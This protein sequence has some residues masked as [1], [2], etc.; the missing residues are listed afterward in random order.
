MTG[1][2]VWSNPIPHVYQ[3]TPSNCCPASFVNQLASVG[4]TIDQDT[5]AQQMG[6]T[7]SGT[8][9]YPGAMTALNKLV[10]TQYVYTVRVINSPA[11]L[12]AEMQY[13]IGA[14]GAAMVAPAIEGRLPWVNDPSSTLGHDI[15]VYGYNTGQSTTAGGAFYCWD[16]VPGRGYEWVTADDLFNALQ[17]NNGS[18]T[19][20]AVYEY[21]EA[22]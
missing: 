12:M 13:E 4:V 9:W 19:Q 10:A 14:F 16:P 8:N 22:W 3:D 2:W 7:S 21:S 15:V 1:T 18:S 6:T 17:A 11:D 5:L 20:K